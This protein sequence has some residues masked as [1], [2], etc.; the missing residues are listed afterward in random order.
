MLTH[1]TKNKNYIGEIRMAYVPKG[2][3]KGKKSRER[4]HEVIADTADLTVAEAGQLTITDMAELSN[5]TTKLNMVM[6]EDL[7]IIL[8]GHK[9]TDIFSVQDDASHDRLKV[10]G[11]G[12]VTIAGGLVIPYG[13]HTGILIA[14]LQATFGD[15]AGLATGFTAVYKD[16]TTAKIYTV[17]VVG[18]AFY[19][20]EAAAAA[21]A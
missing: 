16:D 9:A 11:A 10:D 3:P 7:Y 17:H 4:F 21:A 8:P 5:G 6:E 14:D 19:L 2:A 20:H 18:G 13:H 15:P 12:T 1:I